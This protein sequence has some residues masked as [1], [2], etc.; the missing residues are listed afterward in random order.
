MIFV[1]A[2][3]SVACLPP[4]ISKGGLFQSAKLQA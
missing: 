2:G 3:G 4:E 1:M